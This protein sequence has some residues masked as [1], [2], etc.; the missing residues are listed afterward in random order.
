[1]LVVQRH[2]NSVCLPTLLVPGPRA[3]HIVRLL[4]PCKI[5]KKQLNSGLYEVLQKYA[6]AT[7]TLNY[8]FV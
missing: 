2:T 4:V 6:F 3:R 7:F 5:Q 1:M 8:S